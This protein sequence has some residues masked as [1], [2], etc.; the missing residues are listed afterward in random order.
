MTDK[1]WVGV[2][3][4]GNEGET[5]SVEMINAEERA[6]LERRRCR[7]ELSHR[8]E[9]VLAFVRAQRAEILALAEGNR[10]PAV[11]S[12]A[13]RRLIAQLR[14]IHQPSEMHDQVREMHNEIWY[15]G[16]RGEY[17]HPRIKQDWTVAH[18]A[19][20][21]RWRIK[22]YLFLAETSASEIADII[23]STP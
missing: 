5:A 3:F 20:W 14:S 9:Q 4:M 15:C 7:G 19:S 23:N 12:A 1:E 18:A 21:R 6:E 8:R 2:S 22:E 17:D 13:T 16:Q 11:L 10:D